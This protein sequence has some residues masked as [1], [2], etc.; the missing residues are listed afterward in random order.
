MYLLLLLL[1]RR[2]NVSRAVPSAW[3]RSVVGR[4]RHR[5]RTVWRVSLEALLRLLPGGILRWICQL[6]LSFAM[7]LRVQL[8]FGLHLRWLSYN[9]HVITTSTTPMLNQDKFDRVLPVQRQ[10]GWPFMA[11]LSVPFSSNASACQNF[12][13]FAISQPSTSL[14]SERQTS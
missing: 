8:V 12:E 1:G 14:K 9:K 3:W 5:R 11:N 2:S 6:S 7:H 4:C 13:K 10:K